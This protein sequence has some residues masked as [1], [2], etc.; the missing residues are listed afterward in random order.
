M[1][2]KSLHNILEYVFVG[3]VVSA[4][5]FCI[6]MAYYTFCCHFNLRIHGMCIYMYLYDYSII[7][8]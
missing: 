5:M 8:F 2:A 7:K 6:F 1:Y 3:Y 4:H